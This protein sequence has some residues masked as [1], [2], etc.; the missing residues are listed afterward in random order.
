MHLTSYL[1]VGATGHVSTKSGFWV[2]VAR[3]IPENDVYLQHIGLFSAPDNF[4]VRL[5]GLVGI[6]FTTRLRV[7]RL[8]VGQLIP[9]D[10]LKAW[11]PGWGSE[12]LAS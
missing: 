1:N 8:L 12:Q 11:Q 5:V 3:A 6:V 9:V 7:R 10:A 4:T 2:Y